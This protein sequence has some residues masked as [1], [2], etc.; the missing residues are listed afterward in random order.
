MKSKDVLKL[1]KVSRVTLMTY[2][3]N[4][5]IKATKLSNGLYNYDDAS[6]F[7]FL[8]I[9]NRFNVIYSRV[10]TYKQKNL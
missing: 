3:K 10:S 1:L 5:T 9:D 2:V 8:K 7:K 6:I 4:G